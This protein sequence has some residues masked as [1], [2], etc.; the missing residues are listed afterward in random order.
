MSE[1]SRLTPIWLTV[2]VV[3]AGI[4]AAAP[5]PRLNNTGD[6]AKNDRVKSNMRTLG[7]AFEDFSVQTEGYYPTSASDTTVHGQT[8]EELCPDIDN[9]GVGEWPINPFT[10]RETVIIWGADPSTEGDIGVNPCT[11]FCYRIKGCGRGG[12]LI[13]YE[14][15]NCGPRMSARQLQ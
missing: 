3:A 1:R 8:V 11:D 14:R 13:P 6:F 7:L 5:S 2:L 9:D 4:L 10:G 15:A 12:T